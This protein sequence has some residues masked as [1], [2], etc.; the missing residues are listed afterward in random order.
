MAQGK[1][2]NYYSPT[3]P[4]NKIKIGDCWFDTGY[5]KIATTPTTKAGYLGKFVIPKAEPPI[6]IHEKD[7]IYVKDAKEAESNTNDVVI[8]YIPIGPDEP[9]STYLVKI[10]PENIDDGLFVVKTDST[11]GTDAYETGNLKQ[12]SSLD[13]DGNAA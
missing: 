7:K 12:C 13:A 6:T 2:T 8:R 10:T 3:E 1:T 11:P 9:K 5:V 4:I